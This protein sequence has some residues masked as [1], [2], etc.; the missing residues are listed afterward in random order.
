MSFPGQFAVI[1][2]RIFPS[3]RQ[4]RLLATFPTALA[5]TRQ[6]ILP[7]HDLALD[8][9]CRFELTRC[10]CANSGGSSLS[11]WLFSEESLGEMA[12]EAGRRASV[13]LAA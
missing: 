5:K 7:A 4:A 13:P 9:F 10:R 3:L 11:V 1:A 6:A 2:K 8:A 12:A